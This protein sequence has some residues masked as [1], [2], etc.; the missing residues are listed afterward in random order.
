MVVA[1]ANAVVLLLLLLLVVVFVVVFGGSCNSAIVDDGGGS[2]CGLGKLLLKNMHAV[3]LP[4]CWPWPASGLLLLACCAPGLGEL[5]VHLAHRSLL[6]RQVLVHVQGHRKAAVL[7]QWAELAAA[8]GAGRRLLEG[9]ERRRVAA[10]AAAALRAWLQFSDQAALHAW[11]WVALTRRAHA[12]LLARH[13]HQ[14]AQARQQATL[15]AWAHA[16]QGSRSARQQAEALA[17]VRHQGLGRTALVGWQEAVAKSRAAA[18]LVAKV[19]RCK[20]RM[21]LQ[22][23]T[24]LISFRHQGLANL[25]RSA[26]HHLLFS[27]FSAWL[28]AWHQGQA[29]RQAVAKELH[30]SAAA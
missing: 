21:L 9:V 3:K 16:A 20:L 4:C 19:A 13:V 25:Q 22:A 28:Y 14:Q 1:A 23:W 29:E 26:A 5:L 11:Y 8:H 6:G 15:V 24:G 10:A 18:V 12:C 7:R 27:S 17:A 2:G 30:A